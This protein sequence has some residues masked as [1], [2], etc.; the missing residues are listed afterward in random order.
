MAYRTH[1]MPLFLAAAAFC[2]SVAGN[3]HAVSGT[4]LTGAHIALRGAETLRGV[5]RDGDVVLTMGAGNI[6]A[7][8]QDLK[9][10]LAAGAAA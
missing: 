4:P 8:A 9:A 7:V 6:G 10:R 1:A 3:V 5:L 2:C